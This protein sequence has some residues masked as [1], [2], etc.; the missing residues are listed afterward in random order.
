M[1]PTNTLTRQ[2]RK[3]QDAALRF[4]LIGTCVATSARIEIRQ[5]IDT[6][7]MLTPPRATNYELS[8]LANPRLSLLPVML[9]AAWTSR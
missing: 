9:A 4:S 8:H 2:P 3:L 6:K 5:F 7:C 1:Q